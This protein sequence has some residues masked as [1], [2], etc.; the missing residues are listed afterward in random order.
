MEVL[1]FFNFHLLSLN[2]IHIGKPSLVQ[3]CLQVLNVL[4]VLNFFK[5]FEYLYIL[6]ELSWGYDPSLNM[7]FIHTIHIA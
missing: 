4:Q 6:N 7:K 3:K 5:F 1:F 2:C